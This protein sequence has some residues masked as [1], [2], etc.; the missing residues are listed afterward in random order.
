MPMTGQ[1]EEDATG[2]LETETRRAERP[3]GG[4]A[5]VTVG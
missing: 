1:P 3:L 5:N 2:K 4:I